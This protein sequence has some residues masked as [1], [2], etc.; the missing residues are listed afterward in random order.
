MNHFGL[1]KLL[2]DHAVYFTVQSKIHPYRIRAVVK[3][4]ICL[5]NQHIY[6]RSCTYVLLKWLKFTLKI[7][8]QG[9]RKLTFV[10]E[11]WFI[12]LV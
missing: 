6:V 1:L 12:S 3:Y 8:F 9:C 2:E 11:A 7:T 5:S 4:N 10:S